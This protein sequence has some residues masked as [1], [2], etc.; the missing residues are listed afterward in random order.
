MNPTRNMASTR[1]T[2][3]HR[4]WRRLPSRSRLLCA[5]LCSFILAAP[6]AAWAATPKEEL[7]KKLVKMSA[8]ADVFSEKD[9][10]AVIDNA[11]SD[12]V[13]TEDELKDLSKKGVSA[14]VIEHI[15]ITGHVKTVGA[16][17]G[18]TPPGP[19][20]TPPD[21]VG[22]APVPVDDP[23][24]GK[25]DRA[26]LERI[27]K[28]REAK[29]KKA[30]D[31]RRNLVGQGRKLPE[32]M[33][34]IAAGK[35]M[36]AARACLEYLDLYKLKKADGDQ[37]DYTYNEK[38]E[39]VSLGGVV[40]NDDYYTAKFCLAK[41]LYKQD[42]LSGAVRLLVQ[43]LKVGTGANR[44][45]FKEGFYM[46]ERITRQTQY[47][48][49]E[50]AELTAVNIDSFNDDFKNDFA[51]YMGKFFFKSNDA[52]QAISYL[53]KVKQGAP[54][55]PEALYL[56]G[57]ATLS[58]AA[59]GQAS[60]AQNEQ[61]LLTRAPAALKYFQSAI[62][63]AEAERGGN[64]EILQLGYLAMA[65]VFYELGY[66]NVALFY[67][68]KLP[69]N[70]AKRAEAMFETAWTYFLKN[71]HKRAL[72]TFHTLHSPYFAKW[73][74]PDLYLLEATVY[75]N[76][77]KF[78]QSKMA[79]A[80]LQKRYLDNQAQLKKFVGEAANKDNPEAY[81]WKS[82]TSY[83]EGDGEKR[84]GLPR[85]FANAVINDLNF[86]NTYKTVLVLQRERDELKKGIGALGEFGKVVLASV[87][88]QLENRIITGGLI[89][90]ERLGAVDRELTNINVQAT[91]ISFDI[92][93]EEK[94]VLTRRLTNK[95]YQREQL[96][97]GT[98]LL[99]VSDDWHPWPFEGEYWIDEVNHYRS[100][101]RSQC[102][103]K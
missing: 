90:Q 100:N 52:K 81:L 41:S 31:W 35:N 91:Q 71:D 16:T 60:R 66:Y 2:P 76:M 18:V 43:V 86:F 70:S 59:D 3:A 88:E 87:E 45:Y 12:L 64:Q 69:R 102:V 7:S 103:K 20:V 83:Y 68:Q 28:E 49:P 78:D 63:A 99:I 65:R 19:G 94:D 24:N 44:P 58:G 75:L 25:I 61:E 50:L 93:K 8:L 95:D 13:Y 39:P 47:R 96:E 11:P 55:Y 56:M 22:P 21:G 54:D 15:K 62:V 57:V 29:R 9:L 97:A 98:T 32:A 67:Y 46:L 4:S 37:S 14:K 80:E 17:P 10:K 84:S 1:T 82:L 53:Q 30:E 48:S 26:E 74:F 34:D 42:I 72:G 101:L 5:L 6:A 33:R 77:C 40:P 36:P 23:N 73:Y 89:V 27:I 85:M 38:H 92:E 51:F 79:L